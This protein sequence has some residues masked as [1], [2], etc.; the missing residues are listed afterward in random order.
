[1]SS[2]SSAALDTLEVHDLSPERETM[3]EEVLEG[4]RSDPKTLPCKYFYDE[5]GSQLFE[6]ICEL[7]EYYPTRTELAIMERHGPEM[8]RMLG[9]EVMLL[10]YG[11]GSSRKTEIL[12]GE[13]VDP[14]AYVPIDISR[15][16][17]G[18]SARRLA[19]RF[20]GLEILPVCADYT[21]AF[22]VPE[23]RLTPARRAVYFPGSTLGNFDRP[24]AEEFLRRIA[25]TARRG[26]GLLI[27]IDLEKDASILEPAY[28]DASGVTAD[29]NLNLLAHLN[30]EIHCDFDLGKFRHRAVYERAEGRVEMHL[31]STENQI[32][33][34]GDEAISLRA[35]ESICTE[36]SNKYRLDDFRDMAR[37][38]GLRVER[39]WTDDSNW[40]SVQYLVAEA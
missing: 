1:M 34:V 29:F 10:E 27:G 37:T 24:E 8:A 22:T 9:H 28:D 26:G 19:R 33:H 4:L 13:L 38:A 11:S 3:L 21:A 39:V 20:P 15:E 14:V 30:R 2:A 32:V 6:R 7:D 16:H 36:H 18:L 40:F 31:V 5:R 25:T 12:L 17:L 35:G 23:P